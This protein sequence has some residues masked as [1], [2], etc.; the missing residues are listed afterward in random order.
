M[1][2]PK[3]KDATMLQVTIGL[4]EP[5]IECTNVVVAVEG[6][7]KGGTDLESPFSVK[8]REK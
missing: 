2:A 5:K 3:E 4:D 6:E 7:E 1:E 8:K